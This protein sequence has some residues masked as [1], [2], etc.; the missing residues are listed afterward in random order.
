MTILQALKK[1]K[2]LDRKIE[3]NNK[4]IARWCSYM[5]DEDPMYDADGVK[6]LRQSVEDTIRE[7][8][9]LRHS[10]H[11]TNILTKVEWQHKE[12][13]IDELLILRTLTL[14]AMLHSVTQM[15]RK[16]K[17]Y[18]HDKDVKAVMQYDPAERD[19]TIDSI[20]DTMD[21]LD[22]FLD[23]VNITTELVE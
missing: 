10:I 6:K 17:S 4:R 9:R 2:H 14:P 19:K 15:R 12:F 22:A 8:N 13:T 7:R 21:G 5:D 11:K 23:S 20:E 3:K 1:I 18:N 16:E